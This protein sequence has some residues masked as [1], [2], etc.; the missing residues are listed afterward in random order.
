MNAPVRNLAREHDPHAGLDPK[1]REAWR[2][3]AVEYRKE[4]DK[5]EPLKRDLEAERKATT[6][7]F[8]VEALTPTANDLD[9]CFLALD[10][11]DDVGAAYHFRRLIVA[12]KHAAHGF[13]ELAT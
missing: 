8:I 10:I 4:R 3:S 1:T 9:A 12:I 11:D 2:Q 5:R 7:D 13:R 6:R